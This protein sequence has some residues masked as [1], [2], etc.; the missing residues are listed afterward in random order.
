MGIE[1]TLQGLTMGD[2]G[3]AD[4][5]DAGCSGVGVEPRATPV[6]WRCDPPPNPGRMLHVLSTL[7][8]IEK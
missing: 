1:E 2:L 8:T 6:G 5:A 7:A 3:M 4:E